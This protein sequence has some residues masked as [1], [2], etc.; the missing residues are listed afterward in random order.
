MQYVNLAKLQERALF[1]L[2]VSIVKAHRCT[3]AP[4]VPISPQGATF[5]GR[6]LSTRE[7]Q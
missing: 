4:P 7:I 3:G 2:S 6:S 1:R 5:T